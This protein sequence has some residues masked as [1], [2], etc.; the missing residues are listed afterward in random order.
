MTGVSGSG[1]STLRHRHTLQGALVAGHEVEGVPGQ[2]RQHHRR[3]ADR[4]G[5]RHRPVAHRPDAAVQP[6]H[7]YRR[8]SRRS[9][10]SSAKLPESK[11]RGYKPGRFSFNVPG[12]RCE[13]CEGD[14]VIKIEMHF[15][16]DVYITCE[17]CKGRRYNHE[18]LEV[19]YKGKN[20]YEVLEMTVEEALEFFQNIPAIRTK[21]ETLNRVGLGLHQARPAGHDPLRRRGP[22]G[23]ALDRALQAGDGQHPLPARRAHHGPPFR[24]HPEAHRR[25]QVPGG[26]GEH[27]DRDR[28]Q[29]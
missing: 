13:S 8:S 3:R 5:D 6:G 18:T 25:A 15:L 29:S 17:V 22:A 23:Q 10:T 24:R 2:V 16:P 1:K 28:A 7:L 14:G 4:Q 11:M 19:R 26:Q 12:G 21:L 27:G 9:A 20:I